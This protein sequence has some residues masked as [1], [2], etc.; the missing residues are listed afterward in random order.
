VI[1]KARGLAVLLDF[2]EMEGKVREGLGCE[3]SESLGAFWG[4]REEREQREGEV[5][6]GERLIVAMEEE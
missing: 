3:W 5:R 2:R 6:S 1:V 4:E